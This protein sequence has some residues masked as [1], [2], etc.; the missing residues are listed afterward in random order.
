MK[1][2][3]VSLYEP[4][5]VKLASARPNDVLYFVPTE[6]DDMAKVAQRLKMAMIRRDVR[7]PKGCRFALSS[8]NGS[9]AVSVVKA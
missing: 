6:K 5:L 4:F 3:R 2:H 1:R 7:A 9:V 8:G